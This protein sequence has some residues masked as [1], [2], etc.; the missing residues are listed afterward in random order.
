MQKRPIR[1]PQ[2]G[3]KGLIRLDMVHSRRG[4]VIMGNQIDSFRVKES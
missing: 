2:G 3:E 4:C 1:T